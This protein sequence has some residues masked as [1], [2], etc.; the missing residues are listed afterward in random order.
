M[1]R[2][3]TDDELLD[4]LRA[5]AADEYDRPPT[6]I[7]AN[8]REGFPS[9]QTFVEHFG[10]WNEAVAAAGLRPRNRRRSDEELLADLRSCAESGTYP[11]T[12]AV[13]DRED[14]ASP[15]TYE[16]RFGSWS[17]ALAAAGLPTFGSEE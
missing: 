2:G 15:P 10:S 3:Y 8:A 6:A 13:H 1:T 14:M 9:S 17:D 12:A 7:E 16:K 5:F 11:T 4:A